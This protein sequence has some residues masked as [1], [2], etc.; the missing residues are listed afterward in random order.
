VRRLIRASR[1]EATRALSE[2]LARR[3]PPPEVLVAASA[4][5]YYGDRG[6]ELLDEGSARGRGFLAE[7]AEAWEKACDPARLAG[8]RVVHLRFGI[9]LSRRGGALK[10]LW[11]PFRLGVGG[12]LGHGRQF[13]SWIG[14]EDLTA[15]VG[16]ALQDRRLSGPVNVV[17][18][19]AVRQRDLAGA[20]GRAL[21]RP[22]VMP[23]PA[24]AL[25]L[26]LGGMADEMLLASARVQPARLQ[27]IGFQWRHPGLEDAL[28]AALAP[29][30]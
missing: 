8:I 29:G 27:A 6:D 30:G 1:V 26:V 10:E 7:L 13:W 17:A 25:R 12:P 15:I 21:R 24:A 9:V 2:T 20:L 4:V 23:A 14:L 28:R 11:L 16:E 19:E 3:S 22:S 5:G 18:P